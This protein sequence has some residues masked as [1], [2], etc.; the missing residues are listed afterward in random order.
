MLEST[1][2]V[3]A[4]K[5]A[6]GSEPAEILAANLYG[7]GITDLI[8]R[9]AGDGTISVFDGN[10]SGWFLPAVNLQVGLG[11]SDIEVAALQQTNLLDIVY[12][13]RISGE[14]GVIE[15]LGEGSFG[16][17]VLYRA[18]PGPYGVTP[19][20]GTAK[21]SAVTSLEGTTSV[22]AGIF[23]PGGLTSLVALNPGSNTLG[24]L[25]GLGGEALANPTYIS[26]PGSGLVVRAVDFN[27][28][29]LSG[30]AV[31]TDGGLFIYVSNGQGGFLPPTE[32]NVGFEPNGLTVADL[33]GSGKPDLLV[34]NPR[35]DVQVLIGN[36]DGTFK[37]VQN[38]DQQVGLA[39]YA[40][41]GS[42]PAAF[43][44]TD[45][46]TDQLIVQTVG[47]VTTILGDAS[48]GLVSPG[49][50]ALADLGNNGILDL[51]VANSGSNNVLVFPG[52]GNGQF[53]PALNG[54]H[55][56]YT[57]TNP[58]GITVADLTGNGRL[59]LV[60]ANQGS[61]N[62]SILLNVPDGNGFTFEQGPTIQAGVGPVATA[63]TDV[64]GDGV[65]DLL[66]ANSGSN[67]VW[68]LQGLGNGFF[69]DQSPSILPV[70]TNPSALFV[71]QFSTGSGQDLVTVNSGS[72]TLTVIYG[73]GSGSPTTQTI[74]SGGSDPTAAFETGVTGL[75]Q[76]LVVANSGDGNIALFQPGENGLV[77]S[78]VLSS[79][80][81]PNPSGL[82]L[83]SFSGGNLEFYAS[84]DGEASASLLG[85]ELEEGGAAAAASASE[86]ASSAQLLS[87]TEG[88]L[89]LIGSLLTISLETTDDSSEGSTAEVASAGPGAAGQSLFASLRTPE[90]PDVLLEDPVAQPAVV[91]APELAWARYVMGLD[92]AIESIRAEVDARLIQ[93]AQPANAVEP[94]TTLLEEEAPARAAGDHLVIGAGRRVVGRLV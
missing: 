20:T 5:L 73:L 83:A 2:F 64:S 84:T 15:N 66:I 74:S 71:G 59:D 21:P 48:T 32:Y 27:G 50:V 42:A 92:Q 33:T 68:L 36:G 46:L 75:G 30:L 45:K 1:G 76:D 4:G 60:I 44:Y 29:G 65:P 58:V 9:N 31:L 80:G 77:L 54:G 72:D 28:D 89:A 16:S 79:P 91:A 90:N 87:S 18:G 53:G 41:N 25:N 93:E 57:G 34:S 61:N 82:A 63:V 22:A 52:L 85:F 55:G 26:T 43:V 56:F 23:T 88:S 14:V 10:G 49:A 78:S 3:L 35:G 47:G 69:N 6:T 12:T 81:L 39:V 70:G 94:D 17:P 24:L 62:V 40:P 86:A 8:V 7:N 51:I 37:P 38:L 13:D 11:A 67:N 19:V